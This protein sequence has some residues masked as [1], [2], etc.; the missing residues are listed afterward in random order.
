MQRDPMRLG[1][2]QTQGTKQLLAVSR[3]FTGDSVHQTE[4]VQ[5]AQADIGKI[6]YGRGNQIQ[7]TERII[8]PG[9]SRMGSS[10][11]GVERWVQKSPRM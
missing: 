7:G 9:G 8:L 6:T 1:K 10:A 11:G 4:C 2:V 5:S 3:V